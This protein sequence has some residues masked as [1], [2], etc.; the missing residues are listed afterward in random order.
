[1]Y[2][3]NL[4]FSNFRSSCGA[5]EVGGFNWCI[6][7]HMTEM[8]ALARQM[9]KV[10][11]ASVEECTLQGRNRTDSELKI[12]A[13]ITNVRFCDGGFSSSYSPVHIIGIFPTGQRTRVFED[14]L[15]KEGWTIIEGGLTPH[16]GPDARLNIC[17]YCPQPEKKDEKTVAKNA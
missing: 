16:S 6:N 5:V 4:R 15:R 12:G 9:K 11:F 3:P 14:A 10:P 8:L 17:I 2:L 1:M 7:G 13:G